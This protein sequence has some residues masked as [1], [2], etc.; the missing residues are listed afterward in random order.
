MKS[1]STEEITIDFIP[2]FER[3][4]NI[5]YYAIAKD[6]LLGL[7]LLSD[8]RDPKN[9]DISEQATG[10]YFNEEP[11]S[12]NP[13]LVEGHTPFKTVKIKWDLV[14]DPDGDDVNYY[15]YLKCSTSGLNKY[16]ET[17]YGNGENLKV[18]GND[19]SNTE[20]LA[21]IYEIEY[22]SVYK[23]T[24][25]MEADNN[26]HLGYDINI[27]SFSEDERLEIWIQTRDDYENS[28][29]YSGNILMFDKGHSALPIKQ[30]YPRTNTIVYSKTP[31]IL[32]ELNNDSFE[33]EVLVKW[34]NTT[35]SNKTNPEYFSSKPRASTYSIDGNPIEHNVIFRPPI[36][37]TTKHNSKVPYS[38]KINNTCSI[39][40]ESYYTYYYYNFWENFSDTKFIP[41]KSNHLNYFKEAINNVR[42]AYGLETVKFNRK[43]QKNMILDNED[44]NS[45]DT[46]IKDVNK[47]I[48]EADPTDLLDDN[49]TYIVLED[50]SL[51]GYD[52]ETDTDF[53]E[54][55]Q[56]L[57]LLENM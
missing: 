2:S 42:D 55:Q 31:R 16:K 54:W 53:V 26:Y 15:I 37:Y 48:N 18:D 47:K 20:N 39:S 36:P 14:E 34:G 1:G 24:P 38:V 4:N 8:N 7:G 33:Q 21:S 22:H 17:F 30:A 19:D 5:S 50:Y 44:Y 57:D 13:S 3:S 49:R 10:H 25:Q 52:S 32:I 46:A 11:P 56:L 27:E 12:T 40:N 35:Y 29:Y 6:N 45:A 23:I 41:L 9:I 43:V 51:V 28:Y